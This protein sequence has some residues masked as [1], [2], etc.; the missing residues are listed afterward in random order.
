MSSMSRSSSEPLPPIAERRPKAFTDLPLKRRAA[1]MVALSTL[2]APSSTGS[3][4]REH[5]R[6]VH[7]VMEEMPPPVP[8]DPNADKRDRH[9]A[10]EARRNKKWANSQFAEEA[11]YQ[12]ASISRPKGEMWTLRRGLWRYEDPNPA[13]KPNISADQALRDFIKSEEERGR[14]VQYRN[15]IA[16]PGLM[17]RF[18]RRRPDG[19]FYAEL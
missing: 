9:R 2:W 17:R 11:A 6:R 18:H 7:E 12:G 15:G 3:L 1:E 16:A 13:P 10:H 5:F 8:D 14:G 4:H 19:G